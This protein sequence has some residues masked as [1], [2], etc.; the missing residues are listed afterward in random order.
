MQPQAKNK[1]VAADTKAPKVEM[2]VCPHCSRLLWPNTRFCG[3]CGTKQKDSKN[4]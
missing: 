1:M 2:Q 3:W 4:G